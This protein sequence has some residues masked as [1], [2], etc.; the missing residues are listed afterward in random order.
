VSLRLA[1]LTT[2]EVPVGATLVVPVGSVEQHGPHLPLDTDR[3]VAGELATR[4]CAARDELVLGP[5]LAYGA[6]GEHEGAAGTVSIGTAALTQVLVELGRSATRWATRVLFVNGHG[7]NV[8]AL[9]AAV[10]LLRHEGRDVAWWG[11][12][13]RDGDAHAGAT[14]TSL[15]LALDPAHV[16]RDRIE[17][18]DT[19]ALAE[20][21]P[22]LRARGVLAVSPNGVLGDPTRAASENGRRTWRALSAALV[23]AVDAWSVDADGH[24]EDP[25]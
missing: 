4:L 2:G 5:E 20:L 19:R 17:V 6:S 11:W 18:G 16:R 23:T 14:E 15:L 9:S 13:V 1:A 3:M 12:S 24:L 10:G 25:R 7:G 8:D 22:Q 21:L